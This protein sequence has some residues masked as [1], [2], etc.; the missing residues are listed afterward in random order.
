MSTYGFDFLATLESTIT[1]RLNN[2]S[3]DSYTA[4]LVSQGPKRV[5]QKVGE[6]AVELALAAVAGSRDEVIEESADLLY[7]VFV[8]LSTQD[9]PFTEV[10]AQ[11]QSRHNQ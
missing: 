6:E 5:A 9:I 10:V 2:P 7:H 4:S 11:L 1:E 8:L 3:P